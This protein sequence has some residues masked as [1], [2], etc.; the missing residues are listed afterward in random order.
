[1]EQVMGSS[2]KSTIS[3]TTTKHATPAPEAVPERMTH[4][5]TLQQLDALTEKATKAYGIITV[6]MCANEGDVGVPRQAMHAS[7]WQAQTLLLDID[8]IVRGMQLI[9]AREEM[10][11]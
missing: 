11:P 4:G 5:I 1:M 6:A 10:R 9:T 3:T 7:L 8:A 2:K